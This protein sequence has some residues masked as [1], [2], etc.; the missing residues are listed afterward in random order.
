MEQFKKRCQ[1]MQSFMRSSLFLLCKIENRSSPTITPTPAM[2]PRS[3]TIK[4]SA[5]TWIVRIGLKRTA[6]RTD[7]FKIFP[8]HLPRQCRS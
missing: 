4:C 7:D 2:R 6:D 5:E 3:P 1:M 8:S